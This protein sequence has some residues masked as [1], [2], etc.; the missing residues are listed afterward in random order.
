MNG[1]PILADPRLEAL[2]SPWQYAAAEEEYAAGPI[3]PALQESIRGWSH[4]EA[5]ILAA[6]GMVLGGTDNPIGI[7]NFGT[8]VAVSV[9]AH[10]ALPTSSPSRRSRS[11]RPRSW[12]SRTKSGRS[13][14]G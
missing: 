10:T 7:G 5:K 14:R 2:L 6:G 13:S 1:K 9:M 8:P 4:A 3:S 11:A 12:G